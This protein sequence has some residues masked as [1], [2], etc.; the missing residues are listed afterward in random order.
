VPVARRYTIARPRRNRRT[1][2]KVALVSGGDPALAQLRKYFHPQVSG[3]RH[4]VTNV[5]HD[6]PN[7]AF[8]GRLGSRAGP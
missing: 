3:G 1:T 7:Q 6:I 5:T 2:P 8:Y 4:W